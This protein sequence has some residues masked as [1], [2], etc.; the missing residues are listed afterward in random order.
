MRTIIVV[1][2]AYLIATP[3]LCIELHRLAGPWSVRDIVLVSI[4]TI[5][6]S[7]AVRVSDLTN[8]RCLIPAR[9]G[10]KDLRVL[11]EPHTRA[12]WPAR[13]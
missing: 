2:P 1:R 4:A 3:I 9:D 12:R 5:A 6:M 8:G 11:Q 10:Q 13:L 7:L